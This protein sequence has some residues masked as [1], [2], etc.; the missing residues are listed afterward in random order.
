MKHVIILIHRHGSFEKPPYFLGE[1]AEV[2]KEDGIKVTVAQGPQPGLTGDLAILHVDLTIVPDDHLE[3][4]RGFPASINAGV[5]D[6]SKRAVS[7]NLVSRGDS[8]DGPVIIKTDH[9]A[10]GL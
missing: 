5:A 2:W 3:F 6:I 1:V 8:Y 4:V 9:N 10:G 7:R